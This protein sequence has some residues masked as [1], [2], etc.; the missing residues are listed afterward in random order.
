M[1]TCVQKADMFSRRQTCR[2]N[3][4]NPVAWMAS[5]RVS[6]RLKP[7]DEAS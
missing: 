7:I 2:G 4:H 3:S 1:N 6:D 5:G